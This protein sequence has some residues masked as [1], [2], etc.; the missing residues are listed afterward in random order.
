M[1]LS[2]SLSETF[3]AQIVSTNLTEAADSPEDTSGAG[4]VPHLVDEVDLCSHV[5]AHS[6]DGPDRPVHTWKKDREEWVVVLETNS[7]FQ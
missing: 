5:D 2:H 1:S 6:D 4:A 3:T 7:L